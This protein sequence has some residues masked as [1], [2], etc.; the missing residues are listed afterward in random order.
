MRTL[1]RALVAVTAALTLTA[2]ANVQAEAAEPGLE[3]EFVAGVNRVRA[4]AG[5]PPLATDGELTGVA[6]AWSDRMAGQN[7][8]SHNPNVGNQVGAPWTTIGE[9]VGTGYDVG[10]IMQAFVDSSSHYRNIVQPA[11]DY[12]GVGVT[13]GSDGRMYTTHVFMDLDGG[14]GAPEPEPE[15][16]PEPE[17]IASPE[18][19]SA[20][21]AEAV[22]AAP[23]APVLVTPPAAA[24]PERVVAVLA[25]VGNLGTGLH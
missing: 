18:P 17:P 2:V 12:I 23:E 14:G 10:T 11:Y 6:R 24:D 21:V 1:L 15:A 22:A 19:A 25:L 16:Q 4:N 8:I 5:L 7:A 9:N 13:W 3:S 20:P